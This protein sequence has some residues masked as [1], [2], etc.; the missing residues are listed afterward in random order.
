MK[1]IRLFLAVLTAA[2]VAAA[3]GTSTVTA[4]EIPPAHRENAMGSG[5]G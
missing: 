5:N 3:C 1:M 2:T 4:P